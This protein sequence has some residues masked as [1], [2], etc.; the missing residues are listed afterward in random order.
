MTGGTLLAPMTNKHSLTRK[1]SSSNPQPYHS[2]ALALA[3]WLRCCRAL[4]IL[5]L[6]ARDH[7][8]DTK[9]LLAEPLACFDFLDC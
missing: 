9:I 5:E 3:A 1:A 2:S 6:S 8:G 4:A 7:E